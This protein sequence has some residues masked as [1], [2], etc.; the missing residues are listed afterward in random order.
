MIAEDRSILKAAP[1]AAPTE[2]VM[3]RS[4]V[5]AGVL[6]W[7]FTVALLVILG[8]VGQLQHRPTERV[9]G[10]AEARDRLAAIPARR[11]SLLD[12]RGRVIA[13]SR[14]G[15]RLFADPMLI[16]NVGEFPIHV[17]HAAELD[18]AA[19]SRALDRRWRTRYVPLAP[20]LSDEQLA[21]VRDLN[22]PGIAWQ[23]RAV[24]HYPH[25][26][27]AGQLIGAVGDEQIGLDGLEYQFNTRLTGQS[28]SMRVLRDASRRAVWIDGGTYQPPTDGDAV[29]LSIDMVIQA[30]V[31]SELAAA[32]EKFKAQRA[33]CIVMSATDGQ[34][35]AMANWPSFDPSN[36]RVTPADRRRNQCVTDPYE[37][38]S[39]F[40]PFVFAA[41]LA[42]GVVRTED[43]IDCTDTGVYVSAYGRRLHDARP[44][45]QVSSD[46]VV[47]VSSNIGMAII[48]QRLGA[49]RMYEAVRAFGFG[50]PTGAKLPGASVGIVN[51][52][53]EWNH[54]SETSVPM[55]QEIAV[56]PL[57]LARGL[58]AFA[59]D[60][61]IVTPSVFANDAAD[62]ILTRAVDSATAD[63]LRD[64][65]RRVVTEGTG[66]RGR[67]SMYSIWGKTGT[68]Q[69]PDRIKGGYQSDQYVASFICGAPFDDP[70]I[71]VVVAVHQPDPEIGYYGGTVAAPVAR[72]VVDQ[73]LSYLGVP[74][75]D[76]DSSARS[77]ATAD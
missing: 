74:S 37:P 1:R 55:G 10:R 54:Y 61:H 36:L 38:G 16:E 53:A 49:L 45:G 28:G 25:G 9:V 6:A 23:P 8:R 63:H 18:T 56:T 65:M 4:N 77:V 51:P 3:R 31:E 17:A 58:S 46:D 24:R 62:P 13:A 2:S 19:I 26:P 59:N 76:S 29:R 7:S 52:L 60:G 44:H 48:G 32:C 40:K 12:R 14:V 57:Q 15:H 39:V 69:I 75:S 50:R 64:V 33:Q 20:L 34:I 42:H 30:A 22:L 68:A 72:A 21:K 41:A 70:R 27:L 47:V 73:T 67:S 43:Q 5:L 35:L 66:R 71:V 11:G